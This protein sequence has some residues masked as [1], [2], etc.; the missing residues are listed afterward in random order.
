MP[1]QN[2]RRNLVEA[3][4]TP[5]GLFALVLLIVEATLVGNLAVVPETMRSTIVYSAVGIVVLVILLVAGL[6]VFC[7]GALQGQSRLSL[8]L[9]RAIAVDVCIAYDAYVSNL[10]SPE[11]REEAWETLAQLVRQEGA[12]AESES[13]IAM[14]QTIRERGR[15]LNK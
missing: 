7:P 1:N 15:I 8:E 6:A 5:L 4:K 10:E 9:L 11:E 14:A 12:A 2:E 13:R 3:I